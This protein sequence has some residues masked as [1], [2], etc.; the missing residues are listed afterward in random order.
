VY[1]LETFLILFC[2][3]LTAG[4]VDSI[5]GGGGLIT[6][7]VLLSLGIPPPL[8]L[9]TNK[10]Q[11]SFG[12]LTATLYYRKKG[13]VSFRSAREG[14]AM[15][16]VGAAVGAWTV[17]TV[18]MDLLNDLIPVMLFLIALYT[19]ITPSLGKIHTDAKISQ[20]IF[21]LCAGMGLG[22]YD[23]FFGPGVGSF[24]AMAFIVLQGF[25]MTKA[26]AYTKAMN[27]SSNIVSLIVFAVG[28]SVLYLQGL[29]M[30]AGQ[31][32]GARLGSRLAVRKGIGIIRPL[33]IIV[34][35]ATIGKLLYSRFF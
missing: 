16:M 34:V 27:F 17:Q 14:M 26:T 25:E 13:F 30:A 1:S 11:S 12:S 15:T 19:I 33:Y 18:R 9:G 8:A 22:F 31:L 29:A 6:L 23:G 10:F 7:P 2:T 32:I 21:Y 3:G 20:R 35:L 5:A 4:F 24:W 28:G